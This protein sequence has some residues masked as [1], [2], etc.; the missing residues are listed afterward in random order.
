MRVLIVVENVSDRELAVLHENLMRS[1]IGFESASAIALDP[2]RFGLSTGAARNSKR[3]HG[4]VRTP[5]PPADA[6]VHG[7]FALSLRSL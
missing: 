1:H 6:K 2:V 7:F 5:G 4:V 3:P